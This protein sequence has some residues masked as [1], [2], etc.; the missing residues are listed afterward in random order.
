[1]WYD[2]ASRVKFENNNVADTAGELNVKLETAMGTTEGP[3]LP[4]KYAVTFREIP[5][6]PVFAKRYAYM[7][8]D[9]KADD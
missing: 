6:T 4:D 3:K 2:P 7:S 8:T 9:S 1:M 5:E